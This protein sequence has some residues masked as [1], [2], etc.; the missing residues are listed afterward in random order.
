MVGVTQDY[1]MMFSLLLHIAG[2]PY[3]N[4][5]LDVIFLDSITGASQKVEQRSSQKAIILDCITVYKC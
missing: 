5:L 1:I 2:T 4:M 3:S